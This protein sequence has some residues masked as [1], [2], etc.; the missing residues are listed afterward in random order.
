[1]S[2]GEARRWVATCGRGLEEILEEEL[3]ALALGPTERSIG[4]VSF[5][6]DLAAGIRANWWLRSANRVLFELGEVA[7]ADG[8]A[9]YRGISE[10]VA[11]DASDIFHPERTF[12]VAATSSR[13][14]L[15]DTRWIG[16]RT[17]DA[18]VDEQRRRWG[19]RGDVERRDPDLALRVRVRGDRATLLVDTSGEPLDRRGYRRTTTTAPLREQIAAAAVLAAG[20]PG[21]G[22]VVDPMCGSGTLLAEAGAVRLGRAP[23]RLRTRWGFERLPDFESDL[24]DAARHETRGG[25]DAV[26]LVGA[27]LDPEALAATR[28]NLEAA[29]LLDST[30]LREIDA[31]DLEPPDG[32]GLLVV[33]PPHGGRLAE[34]DAQWRRLGD[35]LKRRY[36]GWTAVVVAGDARL[37]KGIGLRPRRRVPFRNGPL[38]ARI[39]VFDLW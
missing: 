31:F 5:P 26:D 38:E 11:A 8:D 29:G 35:L 19:R 16:L 22:P 28:T 6:G 7:A 1:V 13:S 33:N 37:G 9:L 30:D 32:P 23:N 10:L 18:I 4:G 39:L 2:A 14:Q 36:G 34:G 21:H 17:K 27:D 12:S 24:L 25:V 15:R 20:D 3:R